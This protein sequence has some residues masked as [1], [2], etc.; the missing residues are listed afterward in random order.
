MAENL[1]PAFDKEWRDGIKDGGDG[2]EEE[3]DEVEKGDEELFTA[4]EALLLRRG[5][6]EAAH[7]REIALRK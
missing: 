2:K 4:K 3:E 5:Q 7:K 1:T 6:K